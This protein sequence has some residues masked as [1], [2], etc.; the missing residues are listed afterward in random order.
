MSG[1]GLYKSALTPTPG[2]GGGSVRDVSPPAGS[3]EKRPFLKGVD[4]KGN[5]YIFLSLL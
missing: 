1:V 3:Q 5:S 2:P 4:N